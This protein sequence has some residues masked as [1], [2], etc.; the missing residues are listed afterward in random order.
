ML[1]IIDVQKKYPAAKLI[2]PQVLKEIKKAKR[3]GELIALVNYGGKALTPVY[4]E[5]K[6]IKHLVITKMQ[7]DGGGA[8]FNSLIACAKETW[9]LSSL[10]RINLSK[11]KK[12]RICGV[13]T[14]ACVM[15]TVKS[16]S[17][18]KFPIEV[19]SSACTNEFPKMSNEY[20]SIHHKISLKEMNSWKNVKVV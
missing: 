13:N 6:G 9:N 17:Y 10:P 19:L 2:L 14:S 12:L 15:K 16:L 8:I 20:N 18:T 5:L 11:I 4:K 1:V 3:N 7:D